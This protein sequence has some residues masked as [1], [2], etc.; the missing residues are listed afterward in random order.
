[1]II[2]KQVSPKFS[3]GFYTKLLTSS[4]FRPTQTA[5]LFETEFTN[6]PEALKNNAKMVN[7]T[8]LHFLKLHEI[9]YGE[10]ETC[11]TGDP[12]E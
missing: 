5:K 12:T 11:V 6:F 10:S 4:I 8:K 1:M 9:K 3:S 7:R 2:T